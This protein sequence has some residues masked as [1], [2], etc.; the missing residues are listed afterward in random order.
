MRVKLIEENDRTV[1][2]FPHNNRPA[3][4]SYAAPFNLGMTVHH[5]LEGIPPGRKNVTFIYIDQSEELLC[6]YV[7]SLKEEKETA[8]R[9]AG[10]ASQEV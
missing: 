10:T 5:L 4:S 8:R 6:Y 3:K 7:C 9:Y 1:S 2:V